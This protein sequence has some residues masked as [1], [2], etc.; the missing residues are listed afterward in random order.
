METQVIRPR[1]EVRL[2]P[3]DRITDTLGTRERDSQ[4]VS[5]G[6]G[7]DS[8]LGNGGVRGRTQVVRATSGGLVHSG[9]DPVRVP[10]LPRRQYIPLATRLAVRAVADNTTE[11]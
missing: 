8:V 7:Y 4:V 1:T 5:G 3:F 9:G 6:S 11:S 2:A 10:A